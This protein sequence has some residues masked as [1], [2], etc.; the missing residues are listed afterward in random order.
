MF[1]TPVTV[2]GSIVGDLKRR[3]VG[4]ESAWVSFRS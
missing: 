3:Q 1:E 4:S 2:I